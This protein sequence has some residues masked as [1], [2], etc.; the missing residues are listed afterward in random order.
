MIA[1]CVRL[2]VASN[3]AATC[4]A[5]I[6]ARRGSDT[7]SR[8]FLPLRRVPVDVAVLDCRLEDLR[9]PRQRLVDDRVRQGAHL[10]PDALPP[11]ARYLDMPRLATNC[12]RSRT[13]ARR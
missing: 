4:A 12:S 8:R 9:E 6:D 7:L 10:E 2:V 11:L 1:R 5:P 3:S 13:F